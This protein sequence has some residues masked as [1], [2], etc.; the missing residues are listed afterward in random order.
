M[1]QP[2]FWSSRERFAVLGELEFLDRIEAGFDTARSLLEKLTRPSD[3]R[4]NV[5]RRLTDRLAQ[6]LY[7]L[8][9]ACSSVRGN[10]P[11]D[12]FLQLEAARESLVAGHANHDFARRLGSM[13]RAWAQKRQM[14]FNV[15]RETAREEED[16]YQLL[17]AISGFGAYS[18]L[19]SEH[20][21]HVLEIPA[22]DRD[23]ARAKVQVRIAAQPDE[24]AWEDP[25]TWISQ[26]ET[27]IAATL[28]DTTTVVRRY[29]EEPSPLVR[30]SI[31]KWRT[32]RF[33]RVLAGD[34]DLF[35]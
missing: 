12:A 16:A 7:L 19:S 34:F 18:I 22:E 24:P 2:G 20:G 21:L 31:R 4:Q 29:R 3:H 11:R 9:T 10:G 14:T 8:T 30:D 1:A 32:G 6:Q 15:L 25:R 5:P 27:A 35:E 13:Y 28:K 23:F 26:A 33:D 17:V